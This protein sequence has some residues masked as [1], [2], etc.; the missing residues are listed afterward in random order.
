MNRS[1]LSAAPN[2]VFG[3]ITNN[4]MASVARRQRRAYKPICRTVS[5]LVGMIPQKIVPKQ[6]A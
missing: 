3:A 4:R 2:Y 5:G 1:P 6:D